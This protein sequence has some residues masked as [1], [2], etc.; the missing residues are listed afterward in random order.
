MAERAGAAVAFDPRLTP[1]RPDLA[2]RHLEGKVAA[3]RFV[4]GREREVVEPQAPLRRVPSPEAG[5]DTEALKGER[6][7]VYESEEGWAWGQLAGDGYV[8]YLPANAL[9]EPGPA[10]THKVAVL[11]T[12]AF[13]GPS[14][15]LPPL[16]A[17][18]FGSLIAIARIEA[19][20]AVTA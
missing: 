9:R 8:G 4:D 18:A 17:L 11:R 10:P 15:R 12:L 5:L 3:V 19:A 13:P 2:A 20:F 6:V 1:A 14:I 16:E 7:T